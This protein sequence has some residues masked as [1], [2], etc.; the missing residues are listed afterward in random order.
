[1]KA[2]TAKD[3]VLQIVKVMTNEPSR[4]N[5]HTL[6]V[7]V[8]QVLFERK[9]TNRKEVLDSI[10]RITQTSPVPEDAPAEPEWKT[11][12]LWAL[13][14]NGEVPMLEAEKA[15][16]IVHLVVGARVRILHNGKLHGFIPHE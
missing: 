3:L 4:D 9:D 11:G 1:M 14:F 6:S 5:R 13:H 12:S 7:L 8:E 10:E 2:K 15:A 16:N